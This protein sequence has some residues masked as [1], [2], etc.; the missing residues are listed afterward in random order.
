MTGP[1]LRADEQRLVAALLSYLEAILAM[2]RLQGEASTAESLSQANDLRNALLAAVSHDLRTPLASIKALT[3]G[4]LEPDVDWSRRRH[5]RVHAQHRHGGRS[6]PQAGREPARHEPPAVGRARARRADRP[7]STRSC[8]PRS[9]S[10]S[11]AAHDV[12]VDVPETL[13]RVDVDPTLLERAGRERRRQRGAA[14]GPERSGARRSRGGGRPRRPA[15]RRPRLRDPAPAAGA[16]LPA[17]PA[18]GRHGE[19]DGC[20]ARARS[21]ERVSS[22][23]SAAS[24]PSRTRPAAASRWSSVSRLHTDAYTEERAS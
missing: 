23:P 24:S 5:A 9:P 13:P 3:S 22:T 10:L 11:E 15:R 1:P 17:V 20:R 6:A 16:R 19:R 4:W 8:R 2:H 14:L 18:A 21:R 12:V 7:G